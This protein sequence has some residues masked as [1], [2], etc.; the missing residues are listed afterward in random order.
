MSI[1]GDKLARTRLA[2]IEHVHRKENKHERQGDSPSGEQHEGGGVGGWLSSAKRAASGW[3]RTHPAN[4]GL[5]FATPMLSA[6]AARKPVQFLGI[7]V[8]A[9]AVIMIA[10]PWRL[11][12]ITGLLVALVKSSQLSSVVASALSAADF[13]KDHQTHR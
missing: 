7:A 1:A 12:S 10:R 5:E 11:V 2:I 3:W 6:Y 8:A 9:G 13:H 4:L